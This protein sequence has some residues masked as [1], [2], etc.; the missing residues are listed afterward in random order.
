M[1]MSVTEQ[2]KAYHLRKLRTRC[3]RFDMNHDGYLSREDFELVAKRLVENAS[4]ITKEKTEEIHAAFLSIADLIGLKPGVKIPLDEAA[5][6]GS[7]H[8]LSP[9]SKKPTAHHDLLF[10]CIDTNSD[11]HISI[12]EFKVY[13]KVVGND[14]SD[15][16]IKHSFDAI[17][18]N[19]NGEI[20]REEFV[21][22]AKDFYFGVEETEVSNA[23]YGKLL[24]C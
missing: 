21:A 17:D 8:Y 20:S 7:D 4:G 6:I 3:H 15:E 10:N 24:P 5:K 23:F 22:A 2:Q 11:G 16:E 9:T 19:G 12:E 14:M 1:N 18:S 13:F